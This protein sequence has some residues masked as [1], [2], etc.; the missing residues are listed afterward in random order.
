MGT[1]ATRGASADD[2]QTIELDVATRQTIFAQAH[3]VSADH[4][5]YKQD[6]F[7]QVKNE[8]AELPALLTDSIARFCAD[9]NNAAALLISGLPLDDSLDDIPTPRDTPRDKSQDTS[10][11]TSPEDSEKPG[12]ISEALLAMIGSLL[13][14]TISYQQIDDGALFHDI[15]PKSRLENDQSYASSKTELVFHTEQHFHPYTPDYLL[16]HCLRG[17]DSAMTS[18]VSV[19]RLLG[20]LA[21]ESVEVLRRPLFRSGI[22]HVFGNNRVEKGNGPVYP[23]FSGNTDNPAIRY[24]EELMVPMT[25]QARIAMRSLSEVMKQKACYV[26]L[27][28]GDLLVLDNRHCVHGRTAFTPRYDGT[29]RWLQRSKVICDPEQAGDDLAP[30]G[31]TIVSSFDTE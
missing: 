8:A 2:I 17:D 22:D 11:D 24:D 14:H 27:R 6:F 21:Q 26:C 29:D 23:V 13:G 10:Q 30:D 19:R 20:A 5:R 9:D 25:E 18:Y 31:R 16:L 4:L 12:Q 28:A 15:V 1:G 7:A 3:R